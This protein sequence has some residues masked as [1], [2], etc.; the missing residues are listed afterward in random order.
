MFWRH[1][2]PGEREITFSRYVI[3]GW[4]SF[5]M[6]KSCYS[7]LF[8]KNI[9]K[10]VDLLC[11]TSTTFD[12]ELE[13]CPKC[14]SKKL[15]KVTK[16]NEDAFKIGKSCNKARTTSFCST[17]MNFFGSDQILRR[18]SLDYVSNGNDIPKHVATIYKNIEE[19][20]NLFHTE[21]ETNQYTKKLNALLNENDSRF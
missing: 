10:Y 7:D 20:K 8:K 18:L 1:R 12:A 6:W 4:V 17:C 19:R 13:S 3:L 16:I 5:I 11:Y 2:N 21:H 9:V 15:K 14:R